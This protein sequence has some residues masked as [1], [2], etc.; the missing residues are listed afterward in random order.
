MCLTEHHLKY[1][2]PKKFHIENYNSGAHC[3]R[4]LCEKGGVANFVHNSLCFT[5]TDI[6]HHS[7]D[8][9]IEI[10]ALKLSF[11]TQT[12]CILIFYRAPS[13]KFSIFLLQLHTIIQSL[14][15]PRLHFIICGD[16]NI[17]YLNESGNK[18]QLDN[19]LLSYNL[20]SMLWIM[21]L[22]LTVKM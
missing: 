19:S 4:H 15:T 18:S 9:D 12:I 10:C 17:N 8:R 6:A 11:G 20:T 1:L 14:Y 5:N 2:Q 3:C 7:K 16:I 22:S 21:G 13:G